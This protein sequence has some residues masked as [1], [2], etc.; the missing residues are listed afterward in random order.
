[1]LS[2]KRKKDLWNNTLTDNLGTRAPPHALKNQSGSC[3]ES[4]ETY[5]PEVDP[6]NPAAKIPRTVKPVP[7]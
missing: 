5:E 1:M 6:F 7:P 4:L 2:D 3:W